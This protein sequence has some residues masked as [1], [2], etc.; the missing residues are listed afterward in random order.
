MSRK[1]NEPPIIMPDA[2]Y[3][4]KAG[5]SRPRPPRPRSLERAPRL[6]EVSEADLREPRL[7]T[8]A[9][10]IWNT[11]ALAFHDPVVILLGSAFLLIMLWGYH[12]NLELLGLVVSGWEGPGSSPTLRPQIFPGIPWDHEWL[13]FFGGFVLLVL[14]PVILI[15]KVLGQRLSDYG[16]CLPPRGRRKFAWLAAGTL[17]IVSIPAFYTGIHDAGMRSIYPLYSEFRGVGQFLVYQLGYLLFFIAIEFMFRGYLLFGLYQLRDRDAPAGVSGVPGPLL[18][19]YYAIFVSMLS[20]TAW[21]LGKPLPELWGTL[22]WGLAAGAIV[23]E[24]RSLVP[25]ILTHWVLNIFLDY[26]IWQG[27]CGWPFCNV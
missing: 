21:H 1:G 25:V 4:E 14:V 15:K 7:R 24:S 19:G 10:L 2:G 8:A 18:F 9:K 6:T 13:S 20:Y 17:L 12:G 26:G 27:W 5:A 22:F 11:V 23:L 3:R 16:L